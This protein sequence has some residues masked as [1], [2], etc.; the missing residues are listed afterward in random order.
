MK[1]LITFL[2]FIATTAIFAQ[3]PQG[4]NYQA[5]VRN[6]AGVLIVNQNVYFKFNLMLNSA[7]S[8]PVFSETHYTP[9]DDLG[10]VNI[11]IGQG[12]ATVGTFSTI[13]WGTGNYY[14]GIELNTGGGYIAMGTTQLL[15]VPYALYANSSGNAPT[16][17]PN[18]AAVLAVNNGANNLKISNLAD[19]TVAQDAATKNYVD[20]AASANTTLPDGTIF[21]GNATNQATSVALSGDVTL[22]NTGAAT[23]AN[24]AI[25]TAKI[26]NTNVTN[27]KLDKANIPL[28][29]FGAAT[30]DVNLGTK[31]LTNVA[32]PT[33]AQ[34]AATKNYVDSRIAT[35][36][37]S[38]Q[39]KTSIYLTGNITNAQ[40]VTKIAAELGPYTENIYIRNTTQ[41]T[42]VDLSALLTISNIEINN[43]PNLTTINLSNLSTIEDEF[44]F[45]ANATLSSLS[46]PALLN[47]S[48]FDI[49]NSNGLITLNLPLLR[50][51][52]KFK[53]GN[54]EAGNNA[55]LANLNLPAVQT[56]GGEFKLYGVSSLTSLAFPMLH[57]LS[58]SILIEMDYMNDINITNY[59]FPALTSCLNINGEPGPGSLRLRNSLT[60]TLNFSVLTSCN[61]IYLYKVSSLNFSSLASCSYIE[62][63]YSPSLTSLSFPSLTNNSNLKLNGNALTSNTVNSL[64]NKFLTVAPASGKNINL[65]GQ[66]PPAPPTGQGIIDKQTLIAAGNQVETDGFL[67]VTTAAVTSITSS[68]ATC[69]GTISND[70]SGTILGRGVVWATTTNPT[71]AN[72]VLNNGTSIGSFTSNLT[73]LNPGT[74]YYVR[75]FVT[76]SLGTTYGNERSFTTS[77]ALSTL[78]TSEISQ[79]A[80]NTAVSGGNITSSG[81]GNVSVRGVCWSTSPNPSWLSTTKTSDGSGNGIFTSNLTGLTAGTTYYVRAYAR[82]EANFAYGNEISFTTLPVILPTL[83]TTAV[84]SITST[85]ATSGGNIT[86]DGGATITALGIVWG[87]TTNP[88]IGSNLGITTDGSSTTNFSSN[89][90]NLLPGTTY[91]VRSYATN[92]AGTGYGD[93]KVFTTLDTP[94]I[95]NGTQVWSN[96]NLDVTTYRDGTPIPQVTDPIAWANLT[97]GAWCY[98]NNDPANGAI[99]GKLYNWYAVA[100]IHDNDPNTQNKILAPIGWHIPSDAEWT[101]LITYLGG[102]NIAGG[103]MKSTGTTLWTPSNVGATNSSNFTGYP[104]GCRLFNGS[105]NAIGT[106]GIWWSSSDGAPI[107]AWGR[108]LEYPGTGAYI[109]SASLTVGSSVRLVRD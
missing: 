36:Q 71:T 52:N 1:K 68:T 34:D 14:L 105:F 69:G 101:T 87:T 45:R 107:G 108:S 54:Y 31:K 15:S 39:G 32:D 66:T 79:L 4:F 106:N 35:I 83:G 51:I 57:T 41:L 100:G 75:A 73:G 47:C 60:A 20:N 37:T 18:L 17:I 102:E 103:K 62:I 24:N 61:I 19:P 76:T 64:L 77:A 53:I 44:S 67:I 50:H 99:Y 28:S 8:V 74:T 7:S 5:T 86:N 98:Y 90:I 72:N 59:S 33:T 40:A 65:F 43:N 9:T 22:T 63:Q 91:Y 2:A 96:I 81:G 93:V 104:G 58:G 94:T 78:S 25:T 42:I 89:I 95:T 48:S 30:A 56:I 6:S 85:S 10:Q 16:S 13:N 27:G 109:S 84:T 12:T 46:F 3:A 21:V 23:I 80:R 55:T 29:G 26:A 97:T 88:T 38:S 92:S 82:N 11:V 70:W 49:N